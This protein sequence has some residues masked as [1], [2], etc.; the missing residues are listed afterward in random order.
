MY[1]RK[2]D[3]MWCQKVRTPNG[4]KVV[5]GRTQRELKE[6]LKTPVSVSF[7]SVATEWCAAHVEGISP[8][9]ARKVRNCVRIAVD[10]FKGLKADDIRP[11]DISR[12]MGKIT[13]NR[14]TKTARDYLSILNLLFQ[15]AVQEGHTDY[16]PVTGFKLPQVKPG[17]R[18]L[19][20]PDDIQRIKEHPDGFGLFALIALYTGLRRGEILALRRDDIDLNNRVIYVTKSLQIDSVTKL[21]LPKTENGIRVVGIP[22]GL[23]PYLQN[24][25]AGFLFN[26]QGNPLTEMVYKMRW[27]EYAKE[28]GIT[29]TPHQLR[30][31][32]TTA[33]FDAGIPPE[34][35]QRLLGHADIKT[36]VNVYTHLHKNRAM[37]IAQKTFDLEPK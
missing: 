15:Y 6:K 1:R 19:P 11:V 22:S 34:E 25:P 24:L 18:E 37:E 8:A 30:H 13:A 7:E 2:S 16:N 36:T 27:K 35:A 32:Y 5:Y 12:L 20:S 26:R 14:A 3:N 17:R 23:L 33:L 29:C 10:E 28:A 9:H 31:A 4:Y 21:K